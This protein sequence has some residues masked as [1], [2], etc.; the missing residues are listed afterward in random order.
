MRNPWKQYSKINPQREDGTRQ[1]NN[2]VLAALVRAK[3]PTAEM[4]IV[5]T[6]I[7]KTWG[8]NKKT[9]VISAKQFVDATG[10]TDRAIK[11][12]KVSLKKKCIIQYA[13]SKRVHRGSP[14]ME[15]LFNKHYDTWKLENKGELKDTHEPEFTHGPMNGN[16]KSVDRKG[17]DVKKGEPE[18]MG[19]LSGQERVNQSS[20]TKETITKENIYYADS[21]ESAPLSPKEKQEPFYKTKSGKKLTGKRLE[22][23]TLFW[24][25]FN[26]KQGKASAADSWLNIKPLT[27]RIV[28]DIL[29]AAAIEA[30]RREG[31]IAKGGTPKWAQGWLTERRWEDEVYQTNTIAP[32]AKTT[33]EIQ[34][35]I[36]EK[37]S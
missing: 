24:D 15:Y 36:Q 35:E 32:K 7:S 21:D 3:L 5:L 19:E 23:F 34:A 14:L 25:A 13:P 1:I 31:T 28:A 17:V 22:T 9:D 37:M 26:F 16:S 2:E 33:E 12:A 29:T 18:F 11:K 20:P 6:I 27:N 4:S 10:F 30:E 8:F